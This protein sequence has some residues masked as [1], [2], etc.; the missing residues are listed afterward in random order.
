[1]TD[2]SHIINNAKRREKMTF[3]RP[4]VRFSHFSHIRTHETMQEAIY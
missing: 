4:F 1:M 2:F 3:F